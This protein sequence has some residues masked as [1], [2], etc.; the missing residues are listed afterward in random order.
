MISNNYPATENGIN[1]NRVYHGGH[2]P[3]GSSIL[4]KKARFPRPE[5]SSLKGTDGSKNT[6][7]TIAGY[8]SKNYSY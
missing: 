8:V 4:D 5:I 7:K 3:N 1:G 2:L 6:P